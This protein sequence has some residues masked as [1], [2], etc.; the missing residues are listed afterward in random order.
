MNDFEDFFYDCCSEYTNELIGPNAYGG[1]W[2]RTHE[3]LLE[4]INYRNA[5]YDR[6]KREGGE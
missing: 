5:C 1:D 2:D 6:Y 3:R 4:D